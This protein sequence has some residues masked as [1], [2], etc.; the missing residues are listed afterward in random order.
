MFNILCLI[1]IKLTFIKLM[2]LMFTI[3][4]IY[5]W[6]TVQQALLQGW[7]AAKYPQMKALIGR[8]H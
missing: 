6:F 1:F 4:R 5:K 7:A 2:K 3:Y 8:R